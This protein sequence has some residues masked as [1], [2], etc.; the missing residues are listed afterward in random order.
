MTLD[1]GQSRR[2]FVKLFVV[3]TAGACFRRRESMTTALAQV[4]PQ[5]QPDQGLLRL[6]LTDFPALQKDFGSVRIGTSP[7]GPDNRP[8]GLFYPVII[9]RTANAQFVALDS[10]CTHEGCTVPVFDPA[11]GYIQCPC[12]GS[13][14]RIDGTVQRGPANFPLRQFTTQYDGFN[15]LTVSIPD[16]SFA[17]EAVQ[18]SAGSSR[19][20]LQFIAFDQLEYEIRFR[21]NITA[22]WSAPVPF[23]V[24]PDGPANQTVLL[25]QA[26]IANVFLD[27][28]TACGLY[29]VVLRV[30]QV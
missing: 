26:N 20:R 4:Q 10:A 12:H 2:A 1:Q 17:L 30:A 27:R 24:T 22:A 21:P 16:I 9:N 13:R 18:V 15:S 5:S 29:A 6:R 11:L 25:G 8:V 3:F 28:R 7:I 14:Y 23:A 19:L